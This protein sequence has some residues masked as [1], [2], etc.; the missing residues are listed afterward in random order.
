MSRFD[1]DLQALEEEAKTLTPDQDKDKWMLLILKIA[2]LKASDVIQRTAEAAGTI[3]MLDA[4]L[5]D[6]DTNSYKERGVHIESELWALRNA[7]RNV[8]D[9]TEDAGQ[10][11]D[12]LEDVQRVVKRDTKHV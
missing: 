9:A 8:E 3:R 5:E 7:M 11:T 6:M 12:L 4:S 1:R 2:L 10:I